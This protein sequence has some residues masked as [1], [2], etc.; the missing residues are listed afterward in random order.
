MKKDNLINDLSYAFAL[1]IIKANKFL[2]S[3]RQEYDISRQ[4]LRS[5]TSIGAN[6]REAI[7]GE[8]KTDFIHKLKIALKEAGE[9]E[10]WIELLRDS[11]YFDK[12]AAESMLSDCRRIIRVLV[13]II[14]TSSS[15]II[16][17]QP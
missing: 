16:N 6:V 2:K 4:M 7:N 10:Y 3:E 8:S 5:G 14:K 13:S 11:E 12:E 1:R 15:S 9:T 17:P